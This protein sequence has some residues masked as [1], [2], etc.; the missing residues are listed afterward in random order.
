MPASRTGT[1]RSSIRAFENGNTTSLFSDN[2][3]FFKDYTTETKPSEVLPPNAIR[4]WND[5]TATI[6]V[7]FDGA[8]IHGEVRPSGVGEWYGRA[9][10][11]I[12]LRSPA[13]RV[14]AFRME[15]W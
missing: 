7:S 11:M 4:V 1:S 13:M 3:F 5:G 12:A 9:E 15:A 10:S 6:Y 14:A 8:N 2:L